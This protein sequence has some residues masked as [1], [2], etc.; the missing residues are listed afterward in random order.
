M[1]LLDT[2]LVNGISFVL[3]K[4]ATI[5]DQELNDPARQ[6]ER[7]LEAQ[8]KLDSGEIG[9]DEFAAIEADVFERIREIKTRT[10]PAE[11][12]VD[13]EHRVAGVEIT[14]DDDAS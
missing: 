6:R 3:D 5:A 2:L 1:F 12:I 9:E 11:T 8:L 14:I 7:L 10:Q 4:V 13:E